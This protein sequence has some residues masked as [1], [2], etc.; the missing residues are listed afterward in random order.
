MTRG[1]TVI[2]IEHVMK[3]LMG[4]SDKIMIFHQGEKLA[5]GTPTEI[6]KDEGVIETYLGKKYF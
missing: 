4:L 1:L 5:E 6:A 3:A 2:I